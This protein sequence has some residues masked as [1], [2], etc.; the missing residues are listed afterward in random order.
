MPAVIK[1]SARRFGVVPVVTITF[2]KDAAADSRGIQRR[3]RRYRH[4]RDNLLAFALRW[5]SFGSR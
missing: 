3:H 4:A 2:L 5:F 1:D